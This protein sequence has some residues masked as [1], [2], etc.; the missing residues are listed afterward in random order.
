M[1]P[2][3]VVITVIICITILEAIA[4]LMGYNGTLLKIALVIIAGLGGWRIPINNNVRG[5]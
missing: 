5:K 2:N 4:L 1:K 3:S